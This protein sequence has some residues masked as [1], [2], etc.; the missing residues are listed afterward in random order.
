MKNGP[1]AGGIPFEI[2]IRRYFFIGGALSLAGLFIFVWMIR[3]QTSDAAKGILNRAQDYMYTRKIVY[4]ERGNIYDRWGHLLAGNTEV[5]ELGADLR[6]VEDPDTIAMTLSSVLGMDSNKVKGLLTPEDARPAEGAEAQGAA[7]QSAEHKTVYVVLDNSVPPEKIDEIKTLARQLED[8]ADKVSG[9]QQRNMPSLAGLTFTPRLQRRYPEHTLGSNVIGFYAYKDLQSPR[10]YFG[11]EGKYDHLLAGQ[12][13]EIR[14]PN[15]PYLIDKPPAIPPGASLMLTID[16]E[17]QGMAEKVIDQAVGDNGAQ[18]GTVIIM[19]PRNG[20]ILAMAST[21]RLDPNEYWTYPEI[22]PANTP[23]ARGVEGTYEPGSV[24]KVLTMAAAL[25]SGKVTPD[26]PF[27][28]TG[29]IN[30]GGIDIHNWDRGAWGPQNMIG[31]MQ[32]SL[33]VCLAWTATEMGPSI[34]YGYL[35]RF[36]IGHLTGVDLSGESNWPLA[37]QGDPNW[38]PVNLG[39]NAFG[40]GL[41]VTPIQ[42]VTAVSAVANN[43]GKMMAPHFLKAVIE[44]GEQYDNPPQ[45][46]GTPISAQTAQTLTDML[47]Q[48]L[49]EESSVALVD[50]YRVAGKTGTAEIAGP[51]GYTTGLTN[52]SFVGWGP[53]DDPRFI[54]FIWLEKPTSSIW[55]SVVAA[56]VFS[57]VVKNLVVMLDLPPDA[58]RQELAQQQP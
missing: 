55:G 3:I 10:G 43:Q 29:T 1:S 14:V 53:V 6:D 13:I 15:D 51:E 47:T 22:F 58:V 16:R 8:Q 56:P 45:V 32:H 28:D 31:C 48:S 27:L 54:V 21:P 2:P 41:A 44:D 52:A 40:Q 34:F 30:V 33:N 38:Y 17:I 42:F 4:P 11:I 23:Y 46:I 20:E 26:T 19:D 5:Y 35:Q 37:V 39:T 25:D 24:F 50:G 9:K 57:E 18:S 36:G 12:P 49:E 7:T